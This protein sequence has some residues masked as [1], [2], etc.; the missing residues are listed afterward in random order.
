MIWIKINVT[1]SKIKHLYHWDSFLTLY[2][3]SNIFSILTKI[4]MKSSL[5]MIKMMKRLYLYMFD[6]LNLHQPHF[7]LLILVI[8][9][10]HIAEYLTPKYFN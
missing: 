1:A 8:Y 3:S 5:K 2:N 7:F 10:V 6:T 9:T 4:G